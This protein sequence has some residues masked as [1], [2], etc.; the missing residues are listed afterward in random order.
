MG[1]G[2]CP[3]FRVNR[4]RKT[5]LPPLLAREKNPHGVP[6]QVALRRELRQLPC[7][8]DK[9]MNTQTND[10]GA[11]FPIVSDDLCATG[12][13]LR[14]YF[15]AAALQGMLGLYAPHDY[16]HRAFALAAYNYADAMLAERV[17]IKEEQP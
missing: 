12:M 17:K 16:T 14:D 11:A 9:N 10:G 13:S 5:R 3:L 7:N 4:E 8:L 15:A 2:N 1:N 6:S